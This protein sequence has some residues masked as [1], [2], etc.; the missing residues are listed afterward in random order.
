MAR[1]QRHPHAIDAAQ[2]LGTRIAA[3][4]RARR[5]TEAELA[6]RLGISR[7]TVRRVERGDL[8]VAL[9]TVFDAAA[10]L[11][12]PLFDPDPDRVRLELARATDQ[13]RLLPARVRRS[14]SPGAD[15]F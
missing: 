9:G 7:P 8:G 3:A 5:M 10:L 13:L 14:T 12:V 4:R 2:L 1:A 15:D 6:E 11:G